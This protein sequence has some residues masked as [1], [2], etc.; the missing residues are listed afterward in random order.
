MPVIN[1][2]YYMNPAYGAALERARSNSQS[3][4][5]P[6]LQSLE[7]GSI[8]PMLDFWERS[9][10]SEPPE[11]GS[12]PSRDLSE[13]DIK[14]V[15]VVEQSASPKQ[16]THSSGPNEQEHKAQVGYGETAGLLP[17]KSPDAPPKAHPYDRHA[18][19]QN[20]VSELQKAR[21]HIMDISGR[22]SGV[23]R[24]KPGRDP[25][26]NDVWND[27]M[28]AAANSTGKLPGNYFFIR[29]EGAGPQRPHKNA[30]YG[31]G[32]PIR[33]YGPF[34]NVGGGDVPRGSKTYIDIYDH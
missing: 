34:R 32:T 13:G 8:R 18:W 23:H 9:D 19:D 16:G 26:S 28:N 10:S 30:G 12:P 15:P 31:Q 14:F 21:T 11:P 2:R 22:N 4:L 27:N 6:L 24:A 17:E 33:T 25:I 29:Q 20:S 5:K 7:S 1:G 3:P